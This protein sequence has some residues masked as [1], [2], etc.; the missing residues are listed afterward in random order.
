MFCNL[1]WHPWPAQMEFHVLNL[2]K[3][4]FHLMHDHAPNLF[5][6]SSIIVQ[7][8]IMHRLEDLPHLRYSSPNEPPHL[9]YSSQRDYLKLSYSSQWNYLRYDG[10]HPQ[11]NHLI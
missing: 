11:M 3:L 10:I 7:V 5:D 1:I 4:K 6:E 2:W 9:S 8:Q